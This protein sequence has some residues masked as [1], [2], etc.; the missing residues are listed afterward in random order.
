[1]DDADGLVFMSSENDA[2]DLVKYVDK[3]RIVGVFADHQKFSLYNYNG[4]LKS[5]DD[6]DRDGVDDNDTDGV[7]RIGGTD[8]F[9]GL[10]GIDGNNYMYHFAYAVV[11]KE[12]TKTWLWFM[13]LIIHDLNIRNPYHWTTMSDKQKGLGIAKDK[14]LPGYEHRL[15]IMH[16]YKNLKANH[17]GLVLK[18]IL[19]SAA[20]STRVVDF[21]R[22]MTKMKERDNAAYDWLVQ[23]AP[24]HWSKAYFS[25]NRK[26]D[27][28]LNNMLEYFQ[29]HDSAC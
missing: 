29:C 7:D 6:N 22:A 19:W 15:C 28:L 18:N 14:L 26:C 9:D 17:K 2:L 5:V 4:E 1:M 12:K 23:R 20:R 11:E 10:G 16:L 3:N 21:E 13:D 24:K 27:I 25:L 8:G